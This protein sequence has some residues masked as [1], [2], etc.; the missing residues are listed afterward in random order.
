VFALW[1][2]D[3]TIRRD[4][5]H[6]DEVTAM[7]AALEAAQ[8]TIATLTGDLQAAR[9]QARVAVPPPPVEKPKPE[10]KT[11]ERSKGCPTRE[12]ARQILLD[13]DPVAFE[14]TSNAELGRIH[15]GSD[16]WWG[17]R[18]REVADELA[19]IGGQA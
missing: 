5:D 14:T 3:E 8:A 17:Q 7:H 10:P 13:L 12:A 6:V 18:R 16:N 2:L 1:R 15:G 4:R 11:P 9:A 19:K